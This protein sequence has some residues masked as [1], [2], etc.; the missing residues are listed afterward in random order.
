MSP[1]GLRLFLPKAESLEAELKHPFGFP[2]LG[3]DQSDD[4]LVQA[5]LDDFSMYIRREAELIFLFGYL[6]YI[7]V[8]IL[9]SQLLLSFTPSLLYS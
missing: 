5:F 3:R 2:L 9:I 1:C 7:F 8:F 4:V 6:T